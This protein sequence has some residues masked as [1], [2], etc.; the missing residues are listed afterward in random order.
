MP[1]VLEEFPLL[2][3]EPDYEFPV[4]DI[5]PPAWNDSDSDMEVPDEKDLEFSFEVGCK[6][7]VNSDDSI[8]QNW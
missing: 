1:E 4:Y 5:I 6:S 2:L 8:I 7:T 3:D